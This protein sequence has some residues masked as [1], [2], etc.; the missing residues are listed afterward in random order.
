MKTKVSAAVIFIL[1][2]SAAIAQAKYADLAGTWYSGS[3]SVL[4]SEIR[5]YLSDA[6]VPEIQG[7]PVAFIVPHAGYRFSGPVAAYSYKAAARLNPATA[8]VVGFSHRRYFPGISVFD[9]ES[10]TT[11]LGTIYSDRAITEKLISYDKRIRYYAPAFSGENSIEMQIP[12]IQ[13]AFKDSKIVLVELGPQ[14]HDN[15]TL[16]ANALYDTLKDEKDY[17]ILASTDMSHYLTYDKANDKDSHTVDIIKKFDPELLYSESVKN[18]NELMCG[19]G[20]VVATMIASKKLGADKLSVLKY[21]NS[22][23]TYGDKNRVVGYLSAVLI[24][25]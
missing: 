5:Q 4:S 12:F 11:P 7:E 19:C 18:N 16:L 20:A 9:E 14:D 10:Y 21:A 17:V 23:D 15:I 22:G 13:T 2:I 25:E 24:K 6:D 1:L 8:V 3:P